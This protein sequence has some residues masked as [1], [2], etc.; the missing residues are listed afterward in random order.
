MDDG[1]VHPPADTWGRK[2]RHSARSR[3]QRPDHGISAQDARWP[4][5]SASRRRPSLAS[6]DAPASPPSAAATWA[7][8][9]T[10]W[11]I[12]SGARTIA[13]VCFA[14]AVAS[15]TCIGEVIFA[16]GHCRC[17]IAS[18]M[19]STASPRNG[20]SGRHCTARSAF[21]RCSHPSRSRIAAQIAVLD[22][23]APV[24]G[25]IEGVRSRATPPSQRPSPQRR[26]QPGEG[27]RHPISGVSAKAMMTSS[28]R[29][30]PAHPAAAS[31]ACARTQPS[32]AARR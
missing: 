21:P 11:T 13:I 24:T 22:D 31:T 18:R 3:R 28:A 4:G 10:P 27:L 7:R 12:R 8:S 23:E 17:P 30:P 25:P 16:L 26:A 9:L 15:A 20:Q 6:A 2:I 29:R 14:C 19:P 32:R 5:R 1:V